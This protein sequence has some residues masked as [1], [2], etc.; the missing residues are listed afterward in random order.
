MEIAQPL[1]RD[2][3]GLDGGADGA[4]GLVQMMTVGEAAVAEIGG[5][6]A[7]AAFQ[8]PALDAPRRKLRTPGESIRWPPLSSR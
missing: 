6:L 4:I 3:T 1:R 2:R 5:E 8:I 7:E